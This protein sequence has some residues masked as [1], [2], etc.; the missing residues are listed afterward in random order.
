[1]IIKGTEESPAPS[2]IRSLSLLQP[3]NGAWLDDT[4]N[5]N[6]NEFSVDLRGNNNQMPIIDEVKIKSIFKESYQPISH[7]S[8]NH[9]HVNPNDSRRDGHCFMSFGESLVISPIPIGYPSDLDYLE[10]RKNQPKELIEKPKK[11]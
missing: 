8:L 11:P 5:F 7:T 1:M 2:T 4:L 3:E 9:I 6:D 10:N